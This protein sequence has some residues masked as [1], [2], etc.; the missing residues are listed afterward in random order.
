MPDPGRDVLV[1]RSGDGEGG[2]VGMRLRII[3]GQLLVALPYLITISPE[4]ERT[5]IKSQAFFDHQPVATG[6]PD[7]TRHRDHPGPAT[8]H[9]Q[10][11][12]DQEG[13]LL[14]QRV[15]EFL[16]AT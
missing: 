13:E 8:G 2:V 7:F 4:K 14:R 10:R 12:G 3:P 6:E 9:N 16:I 15:D 5:H 1:V 11:R